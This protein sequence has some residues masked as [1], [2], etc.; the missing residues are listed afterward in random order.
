MINTFEGTVKLSHHEPKPKNSGDLLR[1]TFSEPY[2]LQ[3]H[4]DLIPLYGKQVKVNI[5]EE[6]KKSKSPSVAREFK[7][8]QVKPSGTKQDCLIFILTTPYSKDISVKIAKLWNCECNI[9][10]EEIQKDLEF[11]DDEGEEPEDG[12]E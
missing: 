12:E 7:L 4:L 1:V 11:E 10:M 2:N 5:E 6:P 3:D 8:C 9:S